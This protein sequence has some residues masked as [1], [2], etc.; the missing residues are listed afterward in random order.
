VNFGEKEFKMPDGTEVAPKTSA[1][2]G[3]KPLG[4]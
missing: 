3:L 4:I 2:T 1:V